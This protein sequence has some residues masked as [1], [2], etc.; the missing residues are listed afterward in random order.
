MTKKMKAEICSVIAQD[1]TLRCRYR[2]EQEGQMCVLGGLGHHAGIPLPQ[3]KHNIKEIAYLR[4]FARAL[5]K[6][7][8]LTLEELSELQYINDSNLDIKKRRAALI[9]YV[10]GL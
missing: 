1:A 6:R 5:T 9:K 7:Y 3:G 2:G 4:V 8:G 10:E